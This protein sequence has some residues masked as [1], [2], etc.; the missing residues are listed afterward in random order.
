MTSCLIS[1]MK[2]EE[3][4]VDGASDARDEP[5]ILGV[6]DELGPS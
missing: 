1:S 3:A 2:T 6:F 4:R 5:A